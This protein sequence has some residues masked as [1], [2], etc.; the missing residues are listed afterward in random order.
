MKNI[1]GD[2]TY[3]DQCFLT[4]SNPNKRNYRNSVLSLY[5]G[6]PVDKSPGFM[7]QDNGT[8]KDI[9]DGF[10]IHMLLTDYIK[11]KNDGDYPDVKYYLENNQY[12]FKAQNK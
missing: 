5:R 11:N 6:I 4:K 12:G 8:N 9:D 10:I 1:I 7:N 3:Y 2:K